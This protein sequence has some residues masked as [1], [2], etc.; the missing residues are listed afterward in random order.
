MA[1]N[2]NFNTYL[3]DAMESYVGE[4]NLLYL[5]A[6][7]LLSYLVGS[8]T[9]FLSLTSFVHYMRYISTYAVQKSKDVDFGCWKRDALLFKTLSLAQL[10]GIY[11]LSPGFTVDYVGLAMAASGYI[12]S[13]MATKSLGIDRTYF[14]AELGVVE[15]RWVNQFPYGYIPHPMI[16]SQV[17]ALLGLYHASHM[18][19]CAWPWLVPVHICF[20]LCHMMQEHFGVYFPASI[21]ESADSC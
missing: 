7:G 13:M 11:L 4:K 14:G 16:L 17:W 19:S 2:V 20:Y 3:M 6:V 18:R 12:V 10:W 21:F 1:Y 15:P 8:Y 9:L 5:A